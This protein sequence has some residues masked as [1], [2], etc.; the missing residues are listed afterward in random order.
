MDP[1]RIFCRMEALLEEPRDERVARVVQELA[2]EEQDSLRTT[3]SDS[4]ISINDD[5]SKDDMI[6]LTSYEEVVVGKQEVLEDLAELEEQGQEEAE[7]EEDSTESR[8]RADTARVLRILA[9]ES[10]PPQ[11]WEEVSQLL[12]GSDLSFLQVYAYLEA[13]LLKVNRVQIVVEE[14]LGMAESRREETPSPP[15]ELR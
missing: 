6:D 9:D 15:V 2:R 4:V 3:P 7:E 1:N 11:E 8:L 13:H 14:F 12:P 5:D 10:G